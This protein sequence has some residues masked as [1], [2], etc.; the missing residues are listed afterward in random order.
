MA[1]GC[2]GVNGTAT[3]HGGIV[4]VCYKAKL[5]FILYILMNCFRYDSKQDK[6]R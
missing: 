6:V 2:A 5:S 1:G 4:S 3:E